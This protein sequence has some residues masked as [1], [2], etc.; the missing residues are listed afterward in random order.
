MTRKSPSKSPHQ[1]GLPTLKSPH[2]G[3]PQPDTTKSIS[4]TETTVTINKHGPS[5][6]RQK[7]KWTRDFRRSHKKPAVKNNRK[8]PPAVKQSQHQPQHSLNLP[9]Q[10]QSLKQ[11]QPPPLKSP[12]QLLESQPQLQVSAHVV[13]QPSQSTSA[14]A[15]VSGQ[16][17]VSDITNNVVSHMNSIP[18]TRVTAADVPQKT[19]Q[20]PKMSQYGTVNLNSIPFR[21]RQQQ[22]INDSPKDPKYVKQVPADQKQN[23]DTIMRLN[24]LKRDRRYLPEDYVNIALAKS[25]PSQLSVTSVSEH[26]PNKTPDAVYSYRGYKKLDKIDEGA[27]GTVWKGVR[28]SDGIYV[29]MKEVDLSRKRVK[30]VEEMKR[31]LFVLQKVSHPNVVR[32]IEHFVAGDKLEMIIEYCPGGNLTSYLKE[33]SIEEKE[34]R[35]LFKQMAISIKVLHRLGI[36]HRDVKLNNF[37]L[38][39]T[40]RRIK[41]ADFGLSIVSYR[42]NRGLVMARTYCGTEPYMAPEILRRNSRGFRCYN[43][44]CSD[45]WSLGICLYAMLT[46]TFPFKMNLSQRGLFKAQ[47]MRRWHFPRSMRENLSE[48]IKDLVCHM[49]DPESER[50][51]TINGV[52]QHPW[53]TG[54]EFYELSFY[55]SIKSL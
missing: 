38:D 8:S 14:K 25:T 52:L 18:P 51:I 29:A 36:A 1:P 21:V 4:P 45:I 53:L 39:A 11:Q 17:Q 23:I 47:V 35:L 12:S 6:R 44:I 54:N 7:H 3:A 5:R 31:E 27:F 24:Q 10:P 42:K 22:L 20:I 9:Q 46:R 16:A 37:L 41:V 50:R 32:M 33:T 55:Q 34:A 19:S 28:K 15:T 43:P 40:K 48:E 13:T 30:R 49:L 26:Y 2:T